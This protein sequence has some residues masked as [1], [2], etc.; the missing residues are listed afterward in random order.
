MKFSALVN[1]D[2]EGFLFKFEGLAVDIQAFPLPFS[3]YHGGHGGVS[4]VDVEFL[5]G[6]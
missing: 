6:R 3:H 1:G 4:E 5:G 2:P